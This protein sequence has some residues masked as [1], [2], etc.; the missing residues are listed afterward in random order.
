MPRPLPIGNLDDSAVRDLAS[1]IKLRATAHRHGNVHVFADADRDVFAV[2][3]GEALFDMPG[4]DP[5]GVYSS[6][7]K[8]GDIAADLICA[9]DEEMARRRSCPG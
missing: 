5:I 7:V 9:R 3:H 8:L 1:T 4:H 2:A 6:K